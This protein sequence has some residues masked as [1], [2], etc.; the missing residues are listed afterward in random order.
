MKYAYYNFRRS[1]PPERA[2]VE[3]SI[4]KR[5]RWIPIPAFFMGP[6][7]A[8][9][10]Q[11]SNSY[12]HKNYRINLQEIKE[13]SIN[14]ARALV[15]WLYWLNDID[16]NFE[17]T[18]RNIVGDRWPLSTYLPRPSTV[19]IL[20]W[21]PNDSSAAIIP[22]HHSASSWRILRTQ[23]TVLRSRGIGL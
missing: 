8:N 23:F 14:I 2:C 6:F 1:E 17:H 16:S 3:V 20:E 12:R 13:T 4:P 18:N 9:I 22:T 21:Q 19:K 15:F 5:P 7:T 11:D 10:V